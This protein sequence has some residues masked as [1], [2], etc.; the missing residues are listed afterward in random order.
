MNERPASPL[1]STAASLLYFA[2]MVPIG[3]IL[4]PLWRRSL[5]L[6]FNRQARS[7]WVARSPRIS[8][9]RSLRRQW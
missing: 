6:G 9:R 8:W 2:V 5:R 1:A 4:L 3:V 7:Y